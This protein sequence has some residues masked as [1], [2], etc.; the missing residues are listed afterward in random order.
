VPRIEAKFAGSG[1]GSDRNG[2]L[3]MG[4]ACTIC[5]HNRRHQIEIALAHRVPLR[6]IAARFAVSLDAVGRHRRNHLSPA[7]VAAIL[8]AQKPSEVDLEQLQRSEAEGLLSQLVAQR[9]RLQQ[10]ADMALELGDVGRAIASERAITSNLELVAKL[11]GQL[12][13]HHEVT[14]TSILISA[15]Y[16][17][18]RHA[19]VSALRPFPDAARAVGAALHALESEAAKDIGARK[20]PLTIE[21]EGATA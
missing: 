11:L 5:R 6:V 12:V 16:L 20:A 7:M 10:H 9:A 3:Q 21:H 18:L 4:K 13:Q 14:R 15:D 19:I 2:F 17:Q 1:H 8:A